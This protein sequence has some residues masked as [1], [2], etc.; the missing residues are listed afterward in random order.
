MTP[1]WY[2]TDCLSEDE[3]RI[4]IRAAVGWCSQVNL[5]PAGTGFIEAVCVWLDRSA[6]VRLCKK[7]HQMLR[8]TE[9]PR[10]PLYS[11]EQDS[12]KPCESSATSTTKDL[13]TTRPFY[14]IKDNENE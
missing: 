8:Y 12:S 2:S 5:M 3:Q 11:Q 10:Q 9:T 14:F 7:S 13:D 1:N 4:V 6:Y